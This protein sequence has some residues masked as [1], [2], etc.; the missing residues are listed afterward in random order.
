ML[1]TLQSME[2]MAQYNIKEKLQ[3]VSFPIAVMDIPTV[4]SNEWKQIRRTDNNVF[5]GMCKNK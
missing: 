2:K 4:P 3:P 1:D 5:L